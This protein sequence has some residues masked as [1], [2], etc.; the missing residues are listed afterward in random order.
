MGKAAD[1]CIYDSLAALAASGS[2]DMPR[3]SKYTNMVLGPK[4]HETPV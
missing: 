3:G 2:D 1:S 4:Y